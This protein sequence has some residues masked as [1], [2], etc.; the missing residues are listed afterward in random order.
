MPNLISLMH[1]TQISGG[2]ATHH[3]TAQHTTYHAYPHTHPTHMPQTMPSRKHTTGS[4]AR[5]ARPPAR[6]S[7]Q[8]DATWHASANQDRTTVPDSRTQMTTR[9]WA[10]GSCT[11][12][13]GT[14]I[15]VSRPA[16]QARQAQCKH[17][18]TRQSTAQRG[19]PAAGAGCSGPEGGARG[20]GSAEP[21][22][23]EEE[24]T[25]RHGL[26]WRAAAVRAGPRL[27]FCG[28]VGVAPSP[29]KGK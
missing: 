7:T 16:A 2:S 11:A 28:C 23:G 19:V 25:G 29:R 1:S 4:P 6:S 15:D 27:G 18:H 3:T 22:E 24:K 26:F 12:Q 17:T 8:C 14:R 21:R 5:S 20:S 9:I 13:H 10:A